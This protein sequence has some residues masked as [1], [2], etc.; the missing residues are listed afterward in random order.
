[1]TNLGDEFNDPIDN[2]FD[3]SHLP[4]QAGELPSIKDQIKTA[5]ERIVRKAERAERDVH[6]DVCKACK[7]TGRFRSYTGRDVGE[8]FRCHGKGGKQFLTDAATRAHQTELR[9]ARKAKAE[10]AYREEFKAEI[11][12]LDRTATRLATNRKTFEPSSFETFVLSLK[13]GLAKYGT[14]TDNQIEAIRKCMA[15]DAERQATYQAER[16]QRAQAAPAVDASPILAAFEHARANLIT[17][18][19]TENDVG[20]LITRN[21]RLTLA[22]GDPPRAFVFS[23]AKKDPSIVYVREGETYLGKI[24]EGRFQRVRECSDVTEALVCEA[25]ANPAEAAKAYGLHY[26]HCGICGRMLTNQE[27]RERGIGPYC[28]ARFGF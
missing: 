25:A 28:A 4:K 3:R 18:A 26:S 2:L 27:S 1:M 7:G 8:C 12:W 13:E 16:E 20:V 23:P 24:S 10:D 15:R 21:P 19:P 17:N 6:W 22:A 11:A 9:Q 5:E 14:L